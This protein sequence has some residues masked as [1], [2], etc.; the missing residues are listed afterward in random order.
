[1][2]TPP[3]RIGQWISGIVVLGLPFAI[4]LLSLNFI[5]PPYALP[6][7]AP[8]T[9]FSA[10]RALEQSRRF[11]VEPRP[12]GTAAQERARDYL[13]SRL[14]EI[15]WEAQV[16]EATITQGR[17][18]STVQNVV[19]RFPGK[20]NQRSF[21]LVAHYDTVTTG[22]GAA[23]DGAG[24]VA[25]LETARALKAGPPL[26][27]D[28]V[29]LF[30][31]DEESG[32]R[33]AQ[34]FTEHPWGKGVGAVLNLEARGTCGPSYLFETSRGNGWLIRELRRARVPAV[35]NTLMY[36]FYS[37]SP[38]DTDF[39]VLKREGYP[40][41]NI[42]FIGNVSAYHNVNDSVTKLSPRSI[43]HHG[44]CALALARHFGDLRVEA[45][46]APGKEGEDEVY[47][48]SFGSHLVHYPVSWSRQVSSLS[49]I[50]FLVA[51][52]VGI[53]KGRINLR[54][55]MAGVGAL[56]AAGLLTAF[57]V[58]TFMGIAYWCW[59]VYVLY[60][61]PFYTVSLLV[62]TVAITLAVYWWFSKRSPVLNLAAGAMAWWCVVL[63][64]LEWLLPR[65]TYFASWPL[66]FGSAG[67]LLWC[68]LP[69][70][71]FQSPRQLA[72]MNVFSLP[73]L[74]TAGPGLQ[75][76]LLSSTVIASAAILPLMVL[77]LG[78]IVPQIV[79]AT[80]QC[81]WGLAGGLGAVALLVFGVGFGTNQPN[82]KKPRMDGISYYLNLNR[83]Q[84]V[85]I[86]RDR[87]LDGWTSQFF[88]A[89]IAEDSGAELLPSH[90]RFRA[91]ARPPTIESKSANRAP[92]RRGPAP[93]V[94][95]LEVTLDTVRD[96]VTNGVRHLTLRLASPRKVPRVNLAIAPPAK[97]LLALVNG[98][99]LQ[100]GESGWSLDYVVFPR[101]G[102][103]E[104][105]LELASPEP[106]SITVT[107]ISYELP[108]V[109]G[110]RPRPPHLIP[111]A[112][113]LDW[114]ESILYDP[115]MA[116]VKSFTIPAA[117][118]DR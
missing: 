59:G 41:Y 108:E 109:P 46:P 2:E 114:F 30:T 76:S 11:A 18:I 42:A 17:S 19:A 86:C 52:T 70:S 36:E 77:M 83:Q 58:G 51:V 15:G 38:N 13:M 118:S 26:R 69:S 65:G 47:F 56:F 53:A 72:L 29:L 89:G 43:Q 84:A 112:N 3:A 12:A 62:V 66:L 98:K 63:A 25:L 21:L 106:L 37:R 97:V 104:L 35:G 33:G 28:I 102:T 105:V 34:A 85:W 60:N 5:Q 9:K 91:Q 90:A 101:D 31:G 64:L 107:E 10:A 75:S 57:C 78:T 117:A 8:A 61:A 88:P 50:L 103:A 49:W 95:L 23:D 54:N 45:F 67:L 80:R 6:A 14:Q 7:T 92:Q 20:A 94:R 68:W 116:V 1:M 111:R 32:M 100:G 40:G 115:C 39:T 74:L 81:G 27:N 96:Q 24:V 16:Q 93:A 113:T 82:E 79:F 110:I 22:P 4:A 48:N 99:P 71:A 55:L 87:K 44:E 73:V